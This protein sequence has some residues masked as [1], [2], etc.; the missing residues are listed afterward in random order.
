[1]KKRLIPLL[2]A[3]LM[4]A[5]LVAGCAGD[6]KDPVQTTPAGTD[7]PSVTTPAATDPVQTD[8]PYDLSKSSTWTD[9]QW[10]AYEQTLDFGGREFVMM[11][12]P[13]DRTPYDSNG[14]QIDTEVAHK[15][16]D[17]WDQ[18][19]ADLN[20]KLVNLGDVSHG[21]E[22]KITWLV[23]GENPADI[24]EIKT[25]SWF[26]LY[27]MNGLVKWNSEEMLANGLDINN[28]KF[29]YQNFTHAWDING[30]TYG[31]RFASEVQPPEAGWVCFFNKDL[32]KAA[33][34]PD[35]YQ[36]VRDGDWTWDFFY[37]LAGKITKDTSGDGINDQFGLATGYLGYGEEVLLNDAAIV[38]WKDGKMVS[39]IDTP[40]A[41]ETYGFL[42]KVA[43][44]GYLC[45]NKEGANATYSEGHQ[46]FKAGEVGI[47]WSEMNRAVRGRMG[48][49]DLYNAEIN[50]GTIPTPK[51]TKDG[52]YKNV[53]GGVKY[54]VMF[55]TNKERDISTKIYAA[56]ARR[57]NVE[58][59]ESLLV[60]YLQDLDDAD[61]LDMMKNYIFSKP[62]ANFSWCSVEHNDTYRAE[63]VYKLF[64]EETSPAAIVEAAKPVLQGML[65]KLSK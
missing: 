11:I 60:N 5:A 29:F 65:D 42:R 28:P 62:V 32:V 16:K 4:I 17:I 22:Q 27:A 9:E 38:E 43:K 2:L 51:A 3:V 64:D 57:Q 19:E 20:V 59:Y 21:A 56:F 37:E 36:V 12:N 18:L 48:D 46:M 15:I 58:D 35:L 13:K 61:S 45:E 24:Y 14:A 53:L 50:W 31:A 6:N 26:P 55:V 39:T 40:K 52:D 8:D 33:G 1:M 41:L 7:K 30:D 25:H 49:T 47:L 10:L 23:A 44:S 54:D 34:V 63:V